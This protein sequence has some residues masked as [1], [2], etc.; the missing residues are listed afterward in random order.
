MTDAPGVFRSWIRA[1]NERDWGT[2]R[3]L[4]D[5]EVAMHLGNGNR[6]DGD[7]VLALI[8]IEL[9]W[10]ESGEV[11]GHNPAAAEWRIE[12]GR[13]TEWTFLRREEAAGRLGTER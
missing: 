1:F 13:V 6:V 5:P 2:L 7:T 8:D 4:T 3:D 10:R 9:R 11:A 12:D